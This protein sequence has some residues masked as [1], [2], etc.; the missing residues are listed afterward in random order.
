MHLQNTKRFEA[1]ILTGFFRQEGSNWLASFRM[2]PQKPSIGTIEGK[3]E[4]KRVVSRVFLFLLLGI[5]IT[6]IIPCLRK[7]MMQW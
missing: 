3:H 1:Y 7:K 6:S 2:G 5:Q 4:Q